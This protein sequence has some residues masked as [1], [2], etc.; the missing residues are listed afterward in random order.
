MATL[1]FRMMATAT[2]TATAAALTSASGAAIS[3]AHFLSWFVNRK[4]FYGREP[5]DSHTMPWWAIVAGLVVLFAAIA[6][7]S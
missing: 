3:H 7:L 2:A 4:Q 6:T 1:F 5:D